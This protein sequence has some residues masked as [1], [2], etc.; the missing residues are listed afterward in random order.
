MQVAAGPRK[1]HRALAR[2]T[3]GG[4]WTL[5][6]VV[7]MTAACG[8]STPPDD[9]PAPPLDPLQRILAR[10]LP[11]VHTDT[12][13]GLITGMLELAART[14]ASQA[15]AGKRAWNALY[16]LI[17]ATF[18][19]STPVANAVPHPVED[20]TE[21]GRLDF[22]WLG[23][24]EAPDARVLVNLATWTASLAGGP[25]CFTPDPRRVPAGPPVPLW[26][27]TVS[28]VRITCLD[29]PPGEGAVMQ[30]NHPIAT[31]FPSFARGELVEATFVLP[32]RTIFDE[33]RWWLAVPPHVLSG[34]ILAAGG[35]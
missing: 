24:I 34:F 8:E 11:P 31:S 32:L 14:R 1:G 30:R 26:H 10:P 22:E 5:L 3:A 27:G 20:A 18:W 13:E 29:V 6:T 9:P 28:S 33:G 2:R 23:R 15:E 17:H 12:P 25:F 4:L 19:Q 35:I 7:T 21:L 16:T